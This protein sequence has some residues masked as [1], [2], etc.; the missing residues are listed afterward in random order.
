MSA[1]RISCLAAVRAAAIVLLASA[2]THA[3]VFR[4][5]VVVAKPAAMPSTLATNMAIDRQARLAMADVYLRDR[6]SPVLLLR[7]GEMVHDALAPLDSLLHG[8]KVHSRTEVSGDRIRVVCE[9]DIDTADV[10]LRLVEQGVLSFGRSAPRVLLVPAPDTS[11]EAFR[12]LRVRAAEALRGA[13]IT[14]LEAPPAADSTGRDAGAQLARAAVDV[15]AHFVA[16]VSVTATRGQAPASVVILDG[17]VQFT[18]RRV[19]DAAV[20]DEQAFSAREGGG[21]VEMALGR[22]LDEIGPSAARALAGSVMRALFVNG[23]VVDEASRSETIALNVTR[24]GGASATAAL[25]ALLRARGY[26]AELGTGSSA[27]VD[28]ATRER[29]TVAGGATVE[30]VFLILAEARFGARKELSASIYEHGAGSLG[31]EILDATG[32]PQRE[33]ITAVAL[34][35]ST[36]NGPRPGGAGGPRPN[37]TKP[38]ARPAVTTPLEFEFSAAFDQAMNAGKSTGR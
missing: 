21:S 27:P 2:P 37:D 16:L 35:V 14:V 7:R 36:E 24:R 5:T 33:P 4:T 15:G 18:L 3:E 19:Y 29:I 22:V 26:R 31:L 30:E 12:G 17:Q 13:G 32:K 28:G 25:M 8:F 1:L 34:V 23:R 10:T 11:I 20:L 9:A 6:L 38:A